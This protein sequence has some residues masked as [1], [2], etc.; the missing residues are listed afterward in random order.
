[1]KFRLDAPLNELFKLAYR[2][3]LSIFFNNYAWID[4][5]LSVQVTEDVIFIM[6]EN[7]STKTEQKLALGGWQCQRIGSFI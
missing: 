5:K 6:C 2:Q 3:S 1:M 7:C 4:F